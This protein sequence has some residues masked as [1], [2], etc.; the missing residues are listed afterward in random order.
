LWCYN[1]HIVCCF[2]SF[3]HCKSQNYHII[4]MRE[5]LLFFYWTLFLLG[6]FLHCYTFLHTCIKQ[7]F[8]QLITLPQ[9]HNHFETKW[10][11]SLDF[12]LRF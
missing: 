8:W 3:S 7:E 11:L 10:H 6:L 9:S 1:C 5:A 12:S 2:Y 4:Y